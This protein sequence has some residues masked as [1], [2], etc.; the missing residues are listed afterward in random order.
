MET[1]IKQSEISDPQSIR[2]LFVED[3]ERDALLLVRTLK[4]GGFIVEWTRVDC[5]SDMVDALQNASWDIILCDYCIPGFGAHEALKVYRQSQ[6]DLPFLVVSGTVGEEVAVECMRLG[7]HDYLMKDR[8]TRLCEAVRRELREAESRRC[9]IEAETKLEESS[10]RL[11]TLMDNLPGMAYQCRN[12]PNWPML[13]VSRGAKDLTG[14]QPEDLIAGDQQLFGTIVHPEDR[15]QNWDNIQASL[16]KDGTFIIEYRIITSSGEVKYVREQG[17]GLADASGTYPLLEGIIMDVSERVTYEQSLQRVNA[18]LR[19][20]R[21][22]NQ[23]IIRKNTPE[24]LIRDAVETLVRDRG[25]KHVCCSLT[26]EQGVLSVHAEAAIDNYVPQIKKAPKVGEMVPCFEYTSHSTEMPLLDSDMMQCGGCRY[27]ETSSDCFRLCGLLQHEGKRYGILSVETESSINKTDE[28]KDLFA[29]I[30]GDMGFALYSIE[31]EVEKEQAYRQMEIAKQEA[32]SANHAKDDFLAVM[33]HEL[34]TPLNPIMGFISFMIEDADEDSREMMQCILDSSQRMLLLIE[35][36]LDYSR[37]SQQSVKPSKDDFNLMEACQTA[38][39]EMKGH[40]RDLNY[41][42]NNGG[43]TLLPINENLEVLSDRSILIRILDNLLQNACKYTK[44]GSVSLTV[45]FV[46]NGSGAGQY[47]FVVEDTGIG[48]PEDDIPNLFKPFT[49]V[50]S[51]YSRP[52]EGVGLG[53]AIC[54]RLVKILG[55]EIEAS[56]EFGK[57]SCF[58][59][60]FPFKEKENSHGLLNKSPSPLQEPLKLSRALKILIVEDVVNNMKVACALV[61]RIGGIPFA[62]YDGNEA[63]EHCQK[64]KF[65]AILMDL[66]MPGIDGFETTQRIKQDGQLNANTPIIALT[67]NVADSIQKQCRNYG[68]VD[69]ISKPLMKQVL[70]DTL[71]RIEPERPTA[72]GA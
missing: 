32:E 23:L 1:K 51:S 31:R 64:Q 9:R 41:Q 59:V 70:Y 26:D 16:A 28:E 38:F 61:S 53:L 47:Q 45:G 67:A 10:R 56:S 58:T 25:F 8:L 19:S 34:R 18:V 68:M 49:Q 24:E 57:G 20:I 50:D 29:E 36:I 30:C 55:G 17:V 11:S 39:K 60:S 3:Q 12:E 66:R 22:V 4:Q 44:S 40:S 42:F 15:Q 33:S 6:V 72:P 5:E 54:G 52:Y 48:I 37:F 71:T 35:R 14:H 7:A 69:F 21:S 62:A 63:I 27:Y 46:P 13:F 2:V 43:E 65:D